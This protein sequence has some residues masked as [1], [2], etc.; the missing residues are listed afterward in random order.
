[1]SEIEELISALNKVETCVYVYVEEIKATFQLKNAPENLDDFLEYNDELSKEEI[2]STTV[3]NSSKPAYRGWFYEAKINRI[4]SKDVLQLLEEYT[5]H[6]K[7]EGENAYSFEEYIR[8]VRS[9]YPISVFPSLSKARRIYS[10]DIEEQIEQIEQ[11]ISIEDIKGDDIVIDYDTF[12]VGMGD[13]PIVVV[14][15]D[16]SVLLY[17]LPFDEI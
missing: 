1:M 3:F 14:E 7:A 12:E 2:N 8:E 15:K 5:V 10:L 17:Q 16:F 6:I 9:E 4:H 11:G 13:I